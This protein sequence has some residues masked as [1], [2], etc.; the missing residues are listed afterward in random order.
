[1]N[2]RRLLENLQYAGATVEVTGDRL[3]IDAPV[4]VVTADLVEQ[5]RAHKA[6]LIE[7]LC[8][9]PCAEVRIED[10]SPD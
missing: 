3:R 7:L 6:E 5:M 4:G 1:M 9:S 10:L 8:A 2:A